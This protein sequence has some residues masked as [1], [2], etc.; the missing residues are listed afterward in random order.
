MLASVHLSQAHASM[1]KRT[2]LGPAGLQG[3]V[4]KAGGGWGWH[5]RIPP[6][7]SAAFTCHSSPAN[8]GCTNAP[9]CLPNSADIR[10]RRH[11]WLYKGT[12]LSLQLEPLTSGKHVTSQQAAG[13]KQHLA[14]LQHLTVCSVWPHGEPHA[15]T[16]CW[17]F[18]G[19]K[20][21]QQGQY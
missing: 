15:C 5:C 9:P 8:Y 7:L 12:A 20:R 13:N 17:S 3:I 1:Y 6:S 19:S 10:Q 2:V 11:V 16:W 21:L 4:W 18:G 14:A